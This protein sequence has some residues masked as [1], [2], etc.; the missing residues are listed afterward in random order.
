MRVPE[1]ILVLS[2]QRFKGWIL[3]AF[4]RESSNALGFTPQYIYLHSNKIENLTLGKHRLLK[5]TTGKSILSIHHSN[6]FHL[7]N[8]GILDSIVP[9]NIIVT[10]INS[11]EEYK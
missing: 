1:E 9:H 6:L 2:Q 10:H 5:Q 11:D 3:D 8:I 7:K 4:W